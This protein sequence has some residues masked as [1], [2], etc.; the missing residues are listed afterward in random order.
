MY[1]DSPLRSQHRTTDLPTYTAHAQLL[2]LI[3]LYAS[4]VNHVP[5]VAALNDASVSG[6]HLAAAQS[7]S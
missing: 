1:E 2:L 4:R 3:K 5:H 6:G 7:V